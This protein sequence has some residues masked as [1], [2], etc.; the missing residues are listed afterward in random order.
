[1]GLKTVNESTLTAIGN[2]IRAKLG[3]VTTYKPTQMAAAIASIIELKA[4]TKSITSN[5]TYTPSD[6]KNGFSEVTVNVPNSY[7]ESDEGK[8]VSEGALVAQTSATKNA[9]GTYDTTLNDE[10][11]VNVPNSYSQSDEGKVVSSGALVSQTSA[12]KTANGTY[13]TTTN[14]EV[15]VAVPQPSGNINIT[16]MQSTNVANYATAQVVDADLV[17]GNIKKDVN[18]LGVVGT[19]EGSGGGGSANVAVA[20]V[21]GVEYTVPFSDEYS[22]T[23]SWSG[24]TCETTVY[25]EDSDVVCTLLLDILNRRLLYLCASSSSGKTAKKNED[26]SVSTISLTNSYTYDGKTVYYASSTSYSNATDLVSSMDFI[27]P[28]G[29]TNEN[30]SAWTAV[31]GETGGSVT[32]VPFASGT[33]EQIAAMIQAAHDGDIDLQQDGGWAVGDTRTITVGSFGYPDGS[34]HSQQDVRIVITSF[35]DYNSC[36]CVLQFDFKDSLGKFRMN[37]T[38]SNSGGWAST[39]MKTTTLPSVV[40]A[41]PSWLKNNLI[42]F[43]VAYTAGY[44]SNTVVY[45]TGNK[46]AFR[47]E[48]ELYGLCSKAPADEGTQLNYY[49]TP[50]NRITYYNGSTTAHYLRSCSKN[51]S[52][53]FVVCNWSGGAFDDAATARQGIAPFGCL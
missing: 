12:T 11:V 19:Y 44:P 36:G 32:V 10:V 34:V 37:S 51:D 2:A 28:I 52:G 38:S 50:A 43:S 22:L 4:E 7:E 40:Q 8:V 13:D 31:Y 49:T 25:T 6:G 1:M 30:R 42:E 33:D 15:V 39:E 21:N 35:D 16:D 27:T 41:L 47:S 53:S 45:D 20:T 14:N 26:G 24:N 29:D 18:I 9:N 23:Y 48:M 17:A 5:G 3:V 46:L